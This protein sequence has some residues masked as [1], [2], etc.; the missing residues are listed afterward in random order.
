[1][2]ERQNNTVILLK[3]GTNESCDENILFLKVISKKKL[4][5]HIIQY[6]LGPKGCYN[7]HQK[8]FS[9]DFRKWKKNVP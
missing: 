9:G 5:I 1:M 6:L 3:E 8:W 4:Q 2:N 7:F